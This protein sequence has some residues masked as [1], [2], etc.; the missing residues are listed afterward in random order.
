VNPLKYDKPYQEALGSFEGF[1]K[2]GFAADD[3]YFT[4][5]GPLKSAP[6]T[7]QIGMIQ[8]LLTL[9]TQG[10]QFHIDCGVLNDTPDN[11]VKKWEKLGRAMNE[12][13]IK[14]EH[15]DEVW[16]KSLAHKEPEGFLVALKQ[17]GFVLP[18]EMSSCA[19][20]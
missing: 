14:P 2:L 3:I 1:R 18:K 19:A 5:N 20:F 8:I 9:K 6:F 17:K 7:F 10:K 16:Q 15:L 4:V 11:A 13:R 12:G